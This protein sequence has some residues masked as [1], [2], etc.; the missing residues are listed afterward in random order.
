MEKVKW[1]WATSHR[2][3]GSNPFYFLFWKLAEADYVLKLEGLRFK[4]LRCCE[5]IVGG[6]KKVN[7]SLR[8]TWTMKTYL[9]W[10]FFFQLANES[11]LWS[12]SLE[13]LLKKNWDYNNYCIHIICM[14]SFTDFSTINCT[15]SRESIFANRKWYQ[16][17]FKW[18]IF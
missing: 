14:E 10:R 15:H 9:T 4:W 12:F 3:V 18:I 16:V 13:S 2:K 5:S 6:E 1:K 7:K 17:A 11:N 8:K